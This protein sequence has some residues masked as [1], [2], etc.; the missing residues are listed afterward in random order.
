MPPEDRQIST[1][2]DQTGKANPS[3][4]SGRY[5]GR[6]DVDQ[7]G[8]LDKSIEEYKRNALAEISPMLILRP[9]LYSLVALIVSFFLDVSRVPL[10]GAI[11][12][13][14]AKRMFP[15]WNPENLT[16]TLSL[17][18]MPV[19]FY[20]IF[21]LYGYMAF[22]SLQRE[23]R[24][25]G[26][27]ENIDRILEGYV[28]AVK[29]IS[30]AVPLIGAAILLVSVKLGP[31]VFIGISVPFEIKALLILAI[32]ELF[33]IVF[34]H[35]GVAFNDVINGI[36][37][38]RERFFVRVQ[39]D[40]T[41]LLIKRMEDDLMRSSGAVAGIPPKED[42]AALQKTAEAIAGLS[43]TSL[44]NYRAMIAA[45]Q[46][47][48][49]IPVN[50]QEMVNRMQLLTEQLQVVSQAT[51]VTLENFSALA[52]LPKELKN[53]P[54]LSD[55]TVAKLKSATESLKTISEGLSSPGTQA[56]LKSLENIVAKK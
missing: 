42:L 29:G 41:N 21:V 34:D 32:G 10:L 53:L 2:P 20:A 46:E 6:Q 16:N 55:E 37:D 52:A 14:M 35:M 24:V 47:I 31:E 51:R 15:N 22:R 3:T 43:R 11:S 33:C 39:M 1:P 48:K 30:T 54:G 5:L 4:N 50:L 7:L 26:S 49:T 19:A 40:N 13:E 28:S 36:K 44:E 18:W 25:S 45:A 9:M 27:Y 17:W 8:W 12:V 56:A 23:V 38:L